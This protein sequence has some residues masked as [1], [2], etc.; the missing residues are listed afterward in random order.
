[1]TIYCWNW[2]DLHDG[3][4]VVETPPNLL[5]VVNDFWFRYVTDIGNAGP[6]KGQGGKFLFL[7]PDHQGEVPEGYF[8]FRSPTFG[9]ILFLRGFMQDGDTAP[10]V[11]SLKAGVRIYKLAEAASPPPTTFFDMSGMA[12]NTVHANDFS[13]FEELDELIQEEPVEA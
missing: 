11:A 6:D 4:V 1:E 3:P 2:L 12:I 10:G 8:A 9:D 13:F 5:G 7:P